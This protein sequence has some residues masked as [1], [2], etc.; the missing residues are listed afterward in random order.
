MR[1][2]RNDFSKKG[3]KVKGSAWGML[4]DQ[5]FENLISFLQCYII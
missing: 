4:T 5:K 2:I 3:M 1:K